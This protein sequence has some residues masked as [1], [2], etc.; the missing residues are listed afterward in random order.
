MC[1]VL[2]VIAFVTLAEPAVAQRR[3]PGYQQAEQS[4]SQLTVDE[5]I[6]LQVLLTANGYWPAVPNVNFSSRPC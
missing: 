6:K 5:Q 2:L 3:P 4:S 1:W